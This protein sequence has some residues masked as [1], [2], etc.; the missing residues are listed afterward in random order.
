ML[1]LLLA[2][3]KFCIHEPQAQSSQEEQ[4]QQPSGQSQSGK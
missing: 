2:P 1:L 3:R 4:E